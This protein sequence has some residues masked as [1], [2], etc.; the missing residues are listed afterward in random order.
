MSI[1]P[2]LG[3]LK[4]QGEFWTDLTGTNVSSGLACLVTSSHTLI[5]TPNEE[6]GVMA[7]E[8]ALGPGEGSTNSFIHSCIQQRLCT[9]LCL[10]VHQAGGTQRPLGFGPFLPQPRRGPAFLGLSF[11]LD[12]TLLLPFPSIR[13]GPWSF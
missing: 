9:P 8:N 11:P 13:L 3:L 12:P 5:Y 6:G 4:G 10:A 2:S 1:L 7:S